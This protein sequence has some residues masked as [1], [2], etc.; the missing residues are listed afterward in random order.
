MNRNEEL[1]K[2]KESEIKESSLSELLDWDGN[3]EAT[4]TIEL[5]SV[6]DSRPALQ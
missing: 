3:I 1:D 5:K 2:A 6:G 4:Q